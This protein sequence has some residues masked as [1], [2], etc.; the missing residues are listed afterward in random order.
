MSFHAPEMSRLRLLVERLLD[1]EPLGEPQGATLLAD[2]ES[3]CRHA[4]AGNSAEARR[5]VEKVASFTDAL[6]QTEN[7]SP[8]DGQAVVSA[9]NAILSAASAPSHEAQ[10]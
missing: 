5:Y 3:A 6:I 9:A 10:L 4:D 2:V 7:L 1:E 8:K